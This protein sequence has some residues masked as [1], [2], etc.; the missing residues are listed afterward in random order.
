[1]KVWILFLTKEVFK[2][3]KDLKKLASSID[4]ENMKKEI[5]K[6]SKEI[7]DRHILKLNKKELE[8]LISDK[9]EYEDELGNISVDI[10][11]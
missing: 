6:I 3:I 9:V 1:M 7:E 5:L 10:I 8:E 11:A 4:D 2:M